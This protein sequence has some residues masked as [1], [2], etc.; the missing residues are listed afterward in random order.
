MSRYFNQFPITSGL[1][2]INVLIFGLNHLGFWPYTMS[3]PQT[4][5]SGTFLGHLSHLSLIHILFNMAIL[6]R[7]GPILETHL[8]PS[9]LLQLF[10][11]LWFSL[12]GL[13]WFF[14]KTAL[15]GFS[16]ILM[17]FLVF[18]MLLLRK[19]HQEFSQSLMVLIGLNILIG[20]LPDISFVGHF[21][22]AIMGAIIFGI[23]QG[24]KS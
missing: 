23:S 22:G 8:K 24:I 2:L 3:Y 19:T 21:G 5:N 17:G 6:Y 14:Q 9:G 4:F 10:L 20:F 16:G 7:I 13:L 15:L 1:I 11:S 18:L 12:V